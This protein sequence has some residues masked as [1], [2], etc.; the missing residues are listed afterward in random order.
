MLV[1]SQ[2]LVALHTSHFSTVWPLTVVLAHLQP[3]EQRHVGNGKGYR[4]CV[5][6]V[7][8]SGTPAKADG[9]VADA[10]AG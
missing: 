4:Q 2:V 3:T 10:G 9:E 8:G 7:G 6:A 5:K 1:Y